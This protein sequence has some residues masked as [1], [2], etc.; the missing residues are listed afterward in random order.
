MTPFAIIKEAVEQSKYIQLNVYGSGGINGTNPCV[1]IVGSD[2]DCRAL[3]AEAIKLAHA[4]CDVEQF[5][6]FVNLVLLAYKTDNIGLER[7]YYWVGMQP[8]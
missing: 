1:G 7:I 5:E 3:I 2:S 8:D 4:E 6:E